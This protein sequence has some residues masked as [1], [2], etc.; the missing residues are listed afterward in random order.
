MMAVSVTLVQINVLHLVILIIGILFTVLLLRYKYKS[1]GKLME[2]L[3]LLFMMLVL[4]GIIYL[5]YRMYSI[6]S[7]WIF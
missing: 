1:L 2:T 7:T 5:G 4:V 3:E 6:H